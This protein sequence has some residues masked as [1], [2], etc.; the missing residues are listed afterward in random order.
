MLVR[1]I[2]LLRASAAIACL[3]LLASFAQSYPTKPIHP[4]VSLPAGTPPDIAA[5]LVTEKMQ[6]R[7]SQPIVIENKLGASGTIALAEL[8]RQP[9]DGYTLLVLP[10]PAVAA[11]SLFPKVPLNLRTD[12]VPIGQIDWSYNV[13]VV[14]PDSKYRSLADL[15][16]GLKANPGKLSYASG[17]HGTPAH[18]VAAQMLQTGTS[19]VHMPYNQF[20]QALEGISTGRVDFMV[21]S[22]VAAVP[23]VIAAKMRALA[24]TSPARN[25]IETAIPVRA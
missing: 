14:S 3:W 6:E 25:I 13:R 7:L 22:A 10:S 11:Y 2:T 19:A 15:V 1:S 4:L 23:Q 17:G 20:S 8:A 24:V 12:I 21:L 5:R 18:F 16:A 9:A